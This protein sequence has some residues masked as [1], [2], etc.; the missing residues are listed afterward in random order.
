[1]I[2]ILISIFIC[3]CT[4][5]I[6]CEV[7]L[8]HTYINLNVEGDSFIKSHKNCN[9]D[10][11]ANINEVLAQKS[12]IV[13]TDPIASSLRFDH[14][15][16]TLTPKTINILLSKDLIKQDNKNIKLEILKSGTLKR[17]FGL[18]PKDTYH[19]D[20]KDCQNPGVHHLAITINGREDRSTRKF[21]FKTKTSIEKTILYAN[22]SIHY[23][24]P[25]KKSYFSIKKIFVSDP[26]KY[27]SSNTPIHFF[28][29]SRTVQSGLPLLQNGIRPRMLVKNNSPVKV[30][31]RNGALQ[32]KSIGTAM[33]SG[34]LD[35][36]IT[37]QNTKTKK[38]YSGKIID[39]NKVLVEL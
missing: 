13:S 3:V 11:I 19:A 28:K 17:L 5:I 9:L 39:F 35:E 29:T 18:G 2:K 36:I 34:K 14:K 23:N 22:R 30:I 8:F 6:A 38:A 27:F 33:G 31:L 10:I 24:T 1:M 25:L 26:E 32:M 4:P 7:S 12:G 21:W 20:C 15:G 37:V 16:L